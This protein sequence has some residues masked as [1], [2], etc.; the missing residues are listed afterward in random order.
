MKHAWLWGAIAA[1]A[2]LLWPMAVEARYADGM[3]LYQYVA[4]DPTNQIDPSGLKG[5]K[6]VSLQV[7]RTSSHATVEAKQKRGTRMLYLYAGPGESV[8][9]RLF[10]GL[11]QLI[12][13]K[14]ADINIHETSTGTSWSASLS[15]W[16]DLKPSWEDWDLQ[17]SIQYIWKV[18]IK[19]ICCLSK[20]LRVS[21]SASGGPNTLNQVPPSATHP[22]IAIGESKALDEARLI[23]RWTQSEVGRHSETAEAHISVSCEP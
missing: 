1:T 13:G 22:N 3:N 17:L 12:Y 10:F 21:A 2:S 4:S 19:N 9:N 11:Y 16:T 7:T 15:A 23:A 6:V 20:N 18:S 5:D 8:S 14:H